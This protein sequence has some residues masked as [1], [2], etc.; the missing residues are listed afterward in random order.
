MR[1]RGFLLVGIDV[2]GDYMTEIN[3]TSPTGICEV[4]KFGVADIAALLWDAIERK[5]G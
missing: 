3:V 5:R 2:I 4:R 1:E